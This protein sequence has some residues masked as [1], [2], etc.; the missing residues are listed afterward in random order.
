LAVYVLAVAGPLV[1]ARAARGPSGRPFVAELGSSLGIVALSVLAMQ[2]VLPSRMR[3]FASLGA[4]VA[5]RLHRR[6]AELL[7][8]LIAAHIAIVMVAD[9][10]RLAL[11][12]V[13]D[14]PG[15]AQAAIG[16]VIALGALFGTS[17][18]RRRLRLTYSWWRAGHVALGVGALLLAVVHAW[19]VQRYLAAGPGF[20]ALGVL[21]L[22]GSCAV[23]QLRVARPRR[24]AAQPYVVDRVEPESGGATTVHLRAD[25]HAGRRFEPGQFAWIKPAEAPLAFDEHPFSYSSSAEVPERPSFTIKSYAGFSA[26]AATLKP[27]SLLLVDGP[28]GAFRLDPRAAGAL[29]VAGGIG[30]TPCI[31]VLRTARDRSDARPYFVVYGNRTLEGATFR[32]EL[33]RLQSTLDLE[34]VYVLSR[35][36]AD[37][38]GERGFV[39][40]AA[41]ERHLPDDM[42]GWNFLVCGPPVMADGA[43]AALI[44]LGLPAERVH[45]E[46]FVAV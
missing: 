20:I 14:A 36:G 23:V 26:R 35:P 21:T 3:L 28:H 40:R 17:A 45:V 38:N 29:L 41:L 39:G 19:G 16:S 37:W 13:V 42:R 12:R 1:L 24:L 15:R 2:L 11:L 9:R 7:V 43:L 4:D 46:R 31:S 32:E 22:G 25:G 5:V 10:Q 6:L 33:G 18:I 27:G 30:I 44:E 8:S 34:V